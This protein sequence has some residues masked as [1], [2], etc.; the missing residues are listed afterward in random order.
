MVFPP[1]IWN[2]GMLISEGILLIMIFCCSFKIVFINIPH[3]HFS[4][5]PILHYSIIPTFQL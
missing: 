3:A 2:N 1:H 5:N 4:K